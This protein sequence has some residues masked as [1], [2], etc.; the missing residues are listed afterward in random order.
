MKFYTIQ[1][2]AAYEQAVKTG[3]LSTSKDYVCEDFLS[4]YDW[5]IGQMKDRIGHR[6]T[7]P[8]WLWTEK[9]D[10]N[11]EALLPSGT[12]GVQIEVELPI[13]QVL[14]SD[15]MAWHIVLMNE[16]LALNEEE[17]EEFSAGKCSITKEASWERVFDLQLLNG[18]D[19]WAGEQVIQVTTGEINVSQ[20]KA[21]EHF[22]AK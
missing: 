18:S 21:V 5:M 14:M 8:I 13:E 10:L 2:K 16:F 22:I 4:P 19:Y 1:S 3:T 7:Y 20:F 17:D 9:R 6:G 11:D 15:F 12:S